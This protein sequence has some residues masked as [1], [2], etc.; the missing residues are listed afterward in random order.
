MPPISVEEAIAALE[1]ID[2]PFYLFRNK[3]RA[4][5]TFILCAVT[6]IR[7]GFRCDVDVYVRCLHSKDFI[8]GIFSASCVCDL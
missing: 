1:L 7:A 6:P 2:H 8:V 3:V 5:L 4:S